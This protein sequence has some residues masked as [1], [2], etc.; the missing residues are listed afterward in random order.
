MNAAETPVFSSLCRIE[1]PLTICSY[2]NRNFQSADS[3]TR[4]S[5]TR[6]GLLMLLMPFTCFTGFLGGLLAFHPA[7]RRTALAARMAGRTWAS[8]VTAESPQAVTPPE[9]SGARGRVGEADRR[10]RARR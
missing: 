2:W 6:R 10:G 8:S 9:R 7:A 5:T 1:F 3:A 4:D